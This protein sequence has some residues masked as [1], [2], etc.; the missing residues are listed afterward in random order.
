LSYVVHTDVIYQDLC[1]FFKVKAWGLW[2]LI[3]Q[4]P[5]DV[6]LRTHFFRVS[7]FCVRVLA[8]VFFSCIFFVHFFRAL[9]LCVNILFLKSFILK[10]SAKNLRNFRFISLW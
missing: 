8:C 5:F 7:F 3:K 10:I 2:N 9:F 1:D 4:M 6:F